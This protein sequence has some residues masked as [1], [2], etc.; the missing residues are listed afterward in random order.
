MDRY[1]K[2]VLTLIAFALWAELLAG[3]APGRALVRDANA[4]Q[5]TR[6]VITGSDVSLPVFIVPTGQ[7]QGRPGQ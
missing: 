5:A 2:V 6:V 4:Q 3:F 7:V 1:T